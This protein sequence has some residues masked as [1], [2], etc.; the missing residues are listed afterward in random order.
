MIAATVDFDELKRV[1]R[2]GGLPVLPEV[3]EMLER[4]AAP[5]TR[6]ADEFASVAAAKSSLE[7][8]ERS[9]VRRARLDGHT[10]DEI[11]EYL[12]LSV[13]SARRRYCRIGIAELDA[14]ED[15]H[16]GQMQA[17]MAALK[18][19]R[20]RA[21]GELARERAV[22]LFAEVWQLTRRQ[23]EERAEVRRDLEREL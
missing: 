15:L 16:R 2:V 17:L 3:V 1:C 8:F 18:L 13:Q 23:I 9:L 21:G 14:L 4:W 10:W 20:L 22:E 12:G 11:A 7:E 19:E 5:T 6:S